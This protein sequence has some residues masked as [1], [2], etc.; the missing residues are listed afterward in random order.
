MRGKLEIKGM[1]GISKRNEVLNE[2]EG[3]GGWGQQTRKASSERNETN[4]LM[5][6]ESAKNRQKNM[7]QG[8]GFNNFVPEKRKRCVLQSSIITNPMVMLLSF[9]PTIFKAYMYITNA[10][11]SVVILT[12][13]K[14]SLPP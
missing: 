4:T 9:F 2:R 5:D 7:E 3:R 12:W 14:L 8:A 1:E 11:A 6:G 10:I 13:L